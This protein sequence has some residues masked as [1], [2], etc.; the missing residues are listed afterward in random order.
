[1]RARACVSV[2]R[3][4]TEW[5]QCFT[6]RTVIR[7]A[8][9]TAVCLQ[10]IKYAIRC[11]L[12]TDVYKSRFTDGNYCHLR[13]S[14]TGNSWER[15]VGIFV[16][17]VVCLLQLRAKQRSVCNVSVIVVERLLGHYVQYIRQNS[18]MIKLLSAQRTRS[19]V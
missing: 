2:G 3:R 8:I 16:V 6:V 10:I 14:F 1:V 9:R 5:S 12:S 11:K 17:S 19:S 18:R 15:C 7:T 4:H 13:V